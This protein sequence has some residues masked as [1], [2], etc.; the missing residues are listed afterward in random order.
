MVPKS[1]DNTFAHSL[2]TT[3]HMALFILGKI[4]VNSCIYITA[5]NVVLMIVYMHGYLNCIM[6]IY[7]ANTINF[8]CMTSFIAWGSK[9]V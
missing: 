5:K 9:N 3:V 4:L 1:K 8:K 7:S 6:H 2:Y